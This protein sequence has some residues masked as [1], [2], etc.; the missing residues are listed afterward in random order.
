MAI[1]GKAFITRS[2][3]FGEVLVSHRVGEHTFAV[4]AGPSS[5][6]T[7]GPRGASKE[8]QRFNAQPFDDPLDGSFRKRQHPRLPSC[9]ALRSARRC[10]W[11]GSF[12]P[13]P[14]RT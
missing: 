13:F 6:C 3:Y 8:V 1:D 10:A 11:P 12:E 14:D 9:Q 7:H 4:K 2:S 5:R